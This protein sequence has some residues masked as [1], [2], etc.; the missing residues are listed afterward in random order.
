MPTPPSFQ[1]HA[2]GEATHLRSHALVNA[3]EV[4]PATNA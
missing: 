3:A 2:P 1:H 4:L